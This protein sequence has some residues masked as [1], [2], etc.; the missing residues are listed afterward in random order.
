LIATNTEVDE[1]RFTGRISGRACDGSEKL[2]RV[3]A[4]FGERAVKD[5][6]A[7]GNGTGDRQLLAYVKKA[8]WV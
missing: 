3:V 8:V 6:T 5:A 4:Q 1:G 7:Y 2:G